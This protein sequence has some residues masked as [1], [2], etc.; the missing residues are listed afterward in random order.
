MNIQEQIKASLKDW[1]FENNQ[2]QKTF[3]FDNFVEAIN[4]VNRL[5]SLAEKANHHPDISIQYNKVTISLSTHD[6][7]EVTQKD[8][9]LASEIDK[10]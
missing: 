3:Q 2:I 6:A 4:F 5:A 8:I 1:V 10:I 7:G 9:S